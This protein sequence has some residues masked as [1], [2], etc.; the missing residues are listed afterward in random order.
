VT[1]DFAYGEGQNRRRAKEIL[2]DTN[3][4]NKGTE[5]GKINEKV[6]L[7]KFSLEHKLSVQP[8]GLFVDLDYGFLGASPDGLY[9]HNS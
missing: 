3:F 4:Y 6:A 1:Q 8:S 5:Y 2:H 7:K 9:L